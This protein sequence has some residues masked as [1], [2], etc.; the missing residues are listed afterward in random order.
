MLISIHPL[1]A[2]HYTNV[3][4]C[5]HVCCCCRPHLCQPLALLQWDFSFT[6]CVHLVAKDHD[7]DVVAHRLLNVA[8][9]Q[10]HSLERLLHCDV[11][12]DHHSINSSEKLLSDAAVSVQLH[13]GI[14]VKSFSRCNVSQ[15]VHVNQSSW[16]ISWR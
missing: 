5:V 7:G 16:T 13:K 2:T 4:A 6:L 11:I 10:L 9:P 3:H 8:K 14:A 15:W 1:T 12:D